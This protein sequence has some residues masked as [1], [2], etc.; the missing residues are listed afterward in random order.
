MIINLGDGDTVRVQEG[1]LSELVEEVHQSI[2]LTVEMQPEEAGYAAARCRSDAMCQ[3]LGIVLG[4]TRVA[5]REAWFEWRNSPDMWFA[6]ALEIA[7]RR[8]GKR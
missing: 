6:G 8:A 7:Q 3:A 5:V 1:W 4:V 2:A